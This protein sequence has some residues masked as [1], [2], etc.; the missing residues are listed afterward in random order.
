[1]A[2]R[3][4][5]VEAVKDFIFLGSKITAGSDCSH[6]IKRSLLLGS[7][8]MTNLDSILKSKRHHFADKGPYNQNYSF[9]SSHLWMWEVNHKEGW[10]LKNW[11]FWIVVWEKTLE[12]LGLQGDPTILSFVVPFSSCLQSFPASGSF[13]MSW[14]FASGGQSTEASASVLPMNI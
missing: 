11:C 12:S 6:E 5:K 4:G 14:L 9:S 3:K 7:K 1:M 13:P 8:A 2:N 10:A